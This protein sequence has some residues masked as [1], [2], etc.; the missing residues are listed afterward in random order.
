MSPGEIQERWALKAQMASHAGT[1]IHLQ[2]ECVLNG[3]A[4]NGTCAEMDLLRAFLG[5]T[6]PLLAFRTEW[7]IW[8]SDEELAGCIDFAAID[9]KGHLVLVDWK[10]TK[11]LENKF[12]NPWRALAEPL[13]HLPDAQGI[14][15]HLQLNVYRFIIEKYYGHVVSSMFVVCLHPELQD[16]PWVDEVPTMRAEMCAIMQIRRDQIRRQGCGSPYVSPTLPM[17]VSSAAQSSGVCGSP[18][19]S[20]TL[21]IDVSNVAESSGGRAK[22]STDVL[23]GA[24]L[25][26]I[27]PSD[28]IENIVKD[29][30]VS[31]T[32]PLAKAI[33]CGSPAAIIR[34]YLGPDD[35]G[36]WTIPGPEKL[37]CLCRPHQG[38]DTEED[39]F[40]SAGEG[41]DVDVQPD[42]M[43]SADVCGGGIFDDD[44]GRAD[45][46]NN[47]FPAP[48]EAP[49]ADMEPEDVPAASQSPSGSRR[50]TAAKSQARRPRI[51]RSNAVPETAE[52]PPGEGHVEQPE[53][54]AK[55][56]ANADMDIVPLEDAAF[57]KLRQRRLWP[58]AETSDADFLAMFSS[59]EL[60]NADFQEMPSE[61]VDTSDTILHKVKHWTEHVRRHLGADAPD[62][63]VRVAVGVLAFG[64]SRQA[65]IFLR[66]H[67]LLYWIAEG[68]KS[69]RFHA[70]DCFMKTPSGAFQQHRG[71]P[72]DHGR[73]Q[74]FLMHVEGIFRLMP[75]STPRSAE[76][77]CDAV[78]T[79]WQDRACDLDA[80][81]GAC[82]DACLAFEGDGTGRR[83]R[84]PQG[85]AEGG[86]FGEDPGEGDAPVPAQSTWTASMAK[87][88]MA[89]K[90]QISVELTQDKLLH[91]MSE[92]CDAPKTLEAAVCYDDCAITYEDELLPAV[93]VPRERLENCYLRIP[94]C[95]KQT[96]P[97][98]AM[99]R[100]KRFYAQTFW[101]NIE[102]FRCC[103][104][105]QALARRGLNVVRLFIGLSGGG[106]GQSLYS[107]HLQAMYGHNFAFFDPQIWFN[108][109]EMRKQIEQLN[110]KLREDLYKKFASGDGIAGRKP[111]GFM[112]RMIHCIGWK[113]LEANRM[114]VIDGVDEKNFN[115]M[116]RRAFLYRIKARF[117][118]PHVLANAYSDIHKD[119]VFPKDPDL[120]AFLT[121]SVAAVGG[122]QLQ[123]AFESEHGKE[124]CIA[125][126]ENYVNWGGDHGFTEDTM[127][128]A[129]KLPPKDRRAAVN[130]VTACIHVDPEPDEQEVQRQQWQAVR[131][132]VVEYML[133]RKKFYGTQPFFNTMKIREGPNVAK[134]AMV[135]GLCSSG[136]L[137]KCPGSGKAE[138]QYIPKIGSQ[139]SLASLIQHRDREC[140][141]SLPEVYNLSEFA[142]YMYKHRFRQE[143]AE[144]LVEVLQQAASKKFR[145]AGR[146]TIEEKKQREEL[147]DKAKSLLQGESLGNELF[148]RLDEQGRKR[149]RK[150]RQQDN[151][152]VKEEDGPETRSESLTYHYPDTTPNL[153]S[154]KQ[155]NG[156]GAQ[157]FSQR[158]QMYL[159]KGTH[160]LDIE[161][162]LF[163]LLPQLLE[164]LQLQPSIPEEIDTT[165]QR[166]R[167][168]RAA[169]CS[170]TLHMTLAAGKH[171]LVSV[172][173][174]G[175]PA[176]SI[177]SIDFV[178]N[179][180]KASMYC[181]WV[182]ASLCEDEFRHLFTD[183][184]K[185]H[186]DGSILSYL[187]MACEDF[188]LSHWTNFLVET[189]HPK[190][191]SLHY[192]GVRI[193]PVPEIS[194][195]D[196]CRQ[197]EKYIEEKTGFKLTV[198]EKQHRLTLDLLVA[199][200]KETA[201]ALFDVGHTLR[202]AGNCIPH[203]LACLKRSRLAE[204]VASLE[205]MSLPENVHMEQR[206][207]RTY[208]QA[209]KVW[210]CELK[211]IPLR[212]HTVPEGKFLLHVENGPCPHCVAV[213]RVTAEDGHVNVTVWDVDG[214]RTY[215]GATFLHC[216]HA[217]VDHSTCV[218]F[219]FEAPEEDN[220]ALLALTAA[221]RGEERDSCEEDDVAEELEGDFDDVIFIPSDTEEEGMGG[222]ADIE[223][224]AWLDSS[225]RVTVEEHLLRSL[226][227]EVAAYIVKAKAGTSKTRQKQFPCPACPFRAFN[228]QA[229]LLQHLQ[230]HHTIR[231]SD[232][233][234][235]RFLY[236]TF[237]CSVMVS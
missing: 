103:Q 227:D 50:P 200:A 56:E 95:I 118:D 44:A 134:E 36:F 201:E 39:H 6:R 89:V 69:L 127:R 87:T 187:Y 155:V 42:V 27:L 151:A 226:E 82:V 136:F 9:E 135:A 15:Y 98:D 186:P 216:L 149:R 231:T 188:I 142:E 105:A 94:H 91:Y 90:K 144:L 168:E 74:S 96:V 150:E 131:M 102:V 236:D 170:E 161:N 163:T 108:E 58:G 191:L 212:T 18:H 63:L 203:A 209:A 35:S 72:P 232:A 71:I 101:G 177:A 32:N 66:E 222:S 205:D 16:G 198:R 77:F 5:R 54:E 237:L 190:H 220:K 75:N 84:Q 223:E 22:A 93:Q 221:G 117:E 47:D 119:G 180:Q 59:L 26:I 184:G 213:E 31:T 166:C 99:E 81:L 199:N 207:G 19:A 3:G 83:G 196:M 62:Y 20:P 107:T 111:Y 43:I 165:L 51:D 11:N 215:D 129:C 124:Q 112:T 175:Q 147:Q 229:Q 13:E 185:K 57:D 178:H 148:E 17:D 176:A 230:R 86:M 25:Q 171:A 85:F 104:A 67:A 21:P 158:A 173:Y 109:E 1:W 38:G 14:K 110:G 169:V 233:K 8:A 88:I 125:M 29:F 139:V 73:V 121:S 100:L 76:S 41:D 34:Q 141:L 225:G 48:G 70:G 143:N 7:C 204:K 195:E 140:D 115:A 197:S 208:E 120:H 167:L 28:I 193:S 137:L 160:D 235:Q 12:Q 172:F 52:A 132:A 217:G 49:D 126:I 183:A 179:L 154:R 219:T 114:F 40:L 152:E 24:A 46:E 55:E 162:S 116:L 45:E 146:T 234:Q 79:M 113:R 164:K 78:K 68:G 211:P 130:A 106:V 206:R 138:V 133:A 174:G 30:L 10:R 224:L 37:R 60:G 202:K 123:H 214:V 80:F 122:L 61:P 228:R 181:R 97:P 156:L 218:V 2:C 4:I 192:D 153:R 145:S 159:F 194:V 53:A 64:R 157:K 92:W 182:A 210:A 128:A 23:G 65:D 189:F 33:L